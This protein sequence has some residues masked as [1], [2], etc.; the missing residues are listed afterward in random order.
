MMWTNGQ[1]KTLSKKQFIGKVN[2]Y[3]GYQLDFHLKDGDG[4]Y[5]H[6]NDEKGSFIDDHT[7][8]QNI[9]GERR[10]D[11]MKQPRPTFF[12]HMAKMDADSGM[13]VTI[14]VHEVIPTAEIDADTN[15]LVG[16]Q[17]P[18][19]NQKELEAAKNAIPNMEEKW[20]AFKQ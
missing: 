5:L 18:F 13:S 19:K 4:F 7:L 11:L 2:N 9:S 1:P 20:E 6:P 15:K 3:N 16:L 12:K 14:V 10:K 17:I 8:L